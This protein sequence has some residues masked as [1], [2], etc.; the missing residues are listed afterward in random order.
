MF[1]FT[2]QELIILYLTNTGLSSNEIENIY[3]KRTGEWI[4]KTYETQYKFYMQQSFLVIG[5][6]IGVHDNMKL[7]LFYSYQATLLASHICGL[8]QQ[9]QQLKENT[10]NGAI[11]QISSNGRSVVFADISTIYGESSS[12]ADAIIPNNIKMMLPRVRVW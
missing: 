8:A 1:E 9:S 11:K 4:D 7:E 6:Y 10:S 2:D 12:S 5:N 3:N